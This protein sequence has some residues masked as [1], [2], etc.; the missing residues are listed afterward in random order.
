VPA[1]TLE[2]RSNFFILIRQ[3]YILYFDI[4]LLGD[5]LSEFVRSIQG[6]LTKNPVLKGLPSSFFYA[7]N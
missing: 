1:V 6:V 3:V 5:F 2:A 4:G 7:R